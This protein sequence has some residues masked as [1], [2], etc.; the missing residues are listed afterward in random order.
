ML[1]IHTVTLSQLVQC[2]RLDQAEVFGDSFQWP[3]YLDGESTQTP[4]VTQD[5][6]GLFHLTLRKRVQ[7]GRGRVTT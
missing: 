5:V 6:S 2:L 1:V 4:H 3:K 7:A